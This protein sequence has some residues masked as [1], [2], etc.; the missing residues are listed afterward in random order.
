MADAT[1]W[2]ITAGLLVILELAT[3]TFYLLML[4]LG[5]VAGALAAYGGL[6]PTGQMLVSAL[7]ALATVLACYYWRKQRPGGPSARAERSVNLDV[8][9]TIQIEHWNAD[10]TTTIRY[11]GA[12]WT[13][14]LRSGQTPQSGPHRVIELVGNRLLVEPI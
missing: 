2:W 5:A 13:A 4:A 10:G 3:G 7:V 6:A 9:E 11:R 14:M 8:G 1:L 12:P